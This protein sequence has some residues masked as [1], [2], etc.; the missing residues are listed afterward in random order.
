MSLAC[1]VVI[2][3]IDTE[4]CLWYNTQVWRGETYRDI[5]Y[6]NPRRIDKRID[7]GKGTTGALNG[8]YQILEA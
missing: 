8:Q 4:L 3:V 7:N 5:C 1:Q 2:L 6:G